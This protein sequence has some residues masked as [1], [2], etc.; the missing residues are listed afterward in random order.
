MPRFLQ[1][2]TMHWQLK[3]AAFGLAFLLWVVLSADQVTSR[4][5][6]V[7]IEVDLR[8]P[9]YD[10][11]YGPIPEEVEV[12]FTGPGREILEL[13]ITGAHLVLPVADVDDDNEIF[14]LDPRMVR[15]PRGL[16]ISAQD[17]RPSS[18]RLGF[19]E[20][21]SR[22]VPVIVQLSRGVREGYVLLDSLVV[23]PARLR[24]T[25][26][27]ELVAEVAAAPTQPLD[28]SREDSIFT[29]SVPIDTDPLRGLQV[30]R[31]EVQVSGHVDRLGERV[32][33]AVN[34]ISPAGTAALP[35]RV[36]VRL[37]GPVTLLQR[38]T[39]QNVRVVVPPNQL[40]AQLPSGGVTL[41]LQVE[42]L[43]PGVAVEVRPASVRVVPLLGTPAPP[44]AP[45]PADTV[46]EE[47]PAGRNNG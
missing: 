31:T 26:P 23:S 15:V 18:I 27:A 38:L 2:L 28:L 40:P 21:A 34:V 10:L 1:I 30:G 37:R 45:P 11:V 20:L 14:I 36:E 9:R 47:P 29:R 3:L 16:T 19:A 43:P 33:A 8:D 5:L 46:P 42:Q 41:P 35:P 4:W 25:G 6:S 13:A 22:D 39:A 24:I 44:T 7:P 12:R 32:L 17:V